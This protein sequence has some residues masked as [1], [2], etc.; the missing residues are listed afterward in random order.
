MRSSLSIKNIRFP[1]GEGAMAAAACALWLGGCLS[2]D[3]I[4]IREEACDS[5]AEDPL[6]GAWQKKGKP[7]EVCEFFA[8]GRYHSG[9]GLVSS[10]LDYAKL[11]SGRYYFSTVTGFGGLGR[12]CVGDATFEH[13]CNTLTLSVECDRDGRRRTLHLERIEP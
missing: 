4:P 12:E 7:K 5:A 13:G 8:N 1:L 11:G 10:P 2:A 6:I 9:C 3:A